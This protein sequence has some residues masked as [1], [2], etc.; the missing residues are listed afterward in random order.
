MRED[1]LV[2]VVGPHEKAAV[3]AAAEKAGLNVSAFCRSVLRAEAARL[4]CWPVP[5][6]QPSQANEAVP[7]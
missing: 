3:Q 4:G 7:A 1:R 5:Q 2:A 6:G